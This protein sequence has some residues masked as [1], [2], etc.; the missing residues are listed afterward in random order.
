MQLPFHEM[1]HGCKDLFTF[2]QSHYE[3]GKHINTAEG[4]IGVPANR[5]TCPKLKR[6]QGD[7][8][9]IKLGTREH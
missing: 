6:E 2:V 3:S 8:R 4:H 9:Q 1:Y 7:L 5:G